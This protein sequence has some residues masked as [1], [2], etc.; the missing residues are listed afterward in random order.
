MLPTDYHVHDFSA[1]NDPIPEGS[2]SVGKYDEIRPAIYDAEMFEDTT[3]SVD[4]FS[5]VRDVHVGLDVGGPVGT[6]VLAWS[7]GTV[8]HSGYNPSEGDYGHVVVT[9]HD[10]GGKKVYSLYGHLDRATLDLSPVGR[11]FQAGAA[12]GAIGGREENG[13]WPPHLHFQLSMARPET[14]DLPGVVSRA[15]RAAALEL[16]PDPRLVTGPLYK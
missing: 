5:G 2:W 1:G 3:K 15:D 8:I 6:P 12:L 13:N 11:A 16:Y 9:E 4:G 10:V 7:P 14:H